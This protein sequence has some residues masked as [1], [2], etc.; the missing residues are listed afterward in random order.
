MSSTSFNQLKYIGKTKYKNVQEWKCRKNGT[1]LY[2]GT[3]NINYKYKRKTFYDIR[4]AALFVDKTLI[5]AGKEPVN[6]LKRKI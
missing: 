4:E 3:L 1:T 2:V 5:N 6:I